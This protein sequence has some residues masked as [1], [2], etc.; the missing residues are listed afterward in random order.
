V[1]LVP[2]IAML[3][4]EANGVIFAANHP[5]HAIPVIVQVHNFLLLF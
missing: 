2:L 4:A 1:Q 3:F 5:R